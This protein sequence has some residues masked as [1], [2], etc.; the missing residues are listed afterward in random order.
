[1]SQFD[2][3]FMP[4]VNVMYNTSFE[5]WLLN[6]DSLIALTVPSF[7]KVMLDLV[8][9][10]PEMEVVPIAIKGNNLRIQTG[11][12]SLNGLE[13]SPIS[14][15]SSGWSS[16]P[17]SPQIDFPMK[18]N[19]TIPDHAF[20]KVKEE[21]RI[22]YHCNWTNCKRKFTRRSANCRAHWLRHNNMAP[23]VCLTCSLAFRKNNDLARHKLA[24]HSA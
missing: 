17:T 21:T 3:L 14:S 16:S 1:M 23:L 18:V 22:M 9:S 8:S 12:S 19:P 7:D 24:C 15:V 4:N 6:W 13:M 5:E 11:F 10:L 2:N 20:T